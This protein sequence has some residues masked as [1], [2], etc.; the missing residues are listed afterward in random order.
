MVL[1]ISAIAWAT[2]HSYPTNDYKERYRQEQQRQSEISGGQ[3]VT[4]GVGGNSSAAQRVVTDESDSI[5]P[6]TESDTVT[7]T[8]QNADTAET[9]T[10]EPVVEELPSLRLPTASDYET[11][12]VLTG[13]GTGETHDFAPPQYAEVCDD[14][15]RFGANRDWFRTAFT[16]GWGF[17]FGTNRNDA[18]TVFSYGTARP[19]MKDKTSF[20]SPLESNVG[21]S[22]A[23]N[24]HALTNGIG[25]L[26]WQCLTPSNTFVMTWRN[27]LLDRL[28]D[29]PVSFQM[30][31]EESGGLT[32]RYDLSALPDE[33]VSNLVVSV[34]NGGFARTFTKLDRNTTSLHWSRLTLDDLA[35]PDRDGDGVPTVDELFVHHT[36]PDLADSDADGIADGLELAFGTNPLVRDHDGDGIVDGSDPDPLVATDGLDE[37]GN[38]LPD[39]YEDHWF[40][41]SNRLNAASV[42]NLDE[43]GFA[44]LSKYLA[45]MDP[46]NGVS[47]ATNLVRSVAAAV[48]DGH[49]LRL[50]A[51]LLEQLG[52]RQQVRLGLR[53]QLVQRHDDG[54]TV[55]PDG[56]LCQRPLLVCL[57]HCSYGGGETFARKS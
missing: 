1:F 54:E 30:E 27:V 48:V 36:N 32:F 50:D 8:A 34:S 18:L 28:S 13:I 19:K 44:P 6:T 57:C 11:G 38:G 5:E 29:R 39:A 46:T 51:V 17:A 42:T 7:E 52:D 55:R 33:I 53:R 16:N 12:L 35:N 37:D 9:G 47:V 49:E 22:P 20:F 45:G 2:T 14:W 31:F 43:T 41:V 26:Y 4:A 24:W 10:V 25:S 15:R 40:G 23:S 56:L 21:I 3:G